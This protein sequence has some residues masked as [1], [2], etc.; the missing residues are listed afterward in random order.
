M[1]SNEKKKLTWVPCGGQ[2][3]LKK[4]LDRNGF[5]SLEYLVCNHFVAFS[6]CFCVIITEF[7]RYDEKN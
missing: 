3:F 4:Q 5:I 2:L 6:V 7:A 1:R